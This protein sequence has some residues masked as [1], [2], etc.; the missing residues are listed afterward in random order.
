VADVAVLLRGR[1]ERFW[2]NCTPCPERRCGWKFSNASAASLLA[3]VMPP[4]LL[5]LCMTSS[6]IL[7]GYTM[8]T[9]AVVAVSSYKEPRLLR[10]PPR[11]FLLELRLKMPGDVGAERPCIYVGWC[12]AKVMSAA[13][14]YGL[15]DAQGWR[16]LLLSGTK[17]V[18]SGASRRSARFV[19]LRFLLREEEREVDWDGCQLSAFYATCDCDTYH[20]ASSCT[21]SVVEVETKGYLP[22]LRNSLQGTLPANTPEPEGAPLHLTCE[23][24]ASIRECFQ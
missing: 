13:S 7:T 2:L 19:V 3:F 15:R 10:P 9:S 23:C 5:L 24:R 4:L 18:D 16:D 12:R 17:R 22:R 14:S 11:C 8:L 21:R 6:L 20:C 1:L